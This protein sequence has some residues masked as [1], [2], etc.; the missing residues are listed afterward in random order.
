MRPVAYLIASFSLWFAAAASGAEPDAS[1]PARAE[2]SRTEL[3]MLFI[4]EPHCDKFDPALKGYVYSEGP[5]A[6]EP[7]DVAGRQFAPRA[8]GHPP[9]SY[10]GFL[11]N[12]RFRGTGFF[13][14]RCHILSNCHTA[15]RNQDHPSKSQRSI[16]SFGQDDRT[17]S[18]FA[19]DAVAEPVA[20]GECGCQVESATR[21]NCADIATP[22]QDWALLALAGCSGDGYENSYGYAMLDPLPIR[23][24]ATGELNP[25]FKSAELHAVGQPGTVGLPG[26]KNRPGIDA[27]RLG[28][29][30]SAP[31]Q[32]KGESFGIAW[33]TCPNVS[34]D[35][36]GPIGFLDAAGRLHVVAIQQSQGGREGTN[37]ETD[38]ERVEDWSRDITNFAVPVAG[39]YGRIAPYIG[40]DQDRL[41]R[42]PLP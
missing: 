10:V 38:V 30:I 41:R 25:A 39:F 8:P 42:K 7:C 28:A 26:E 4:L 32:I 27:Y 20:W 3:A 31:C 6:G 36:G 5:R 19:R 13:V 35:S 34:G 17:R 18:S 23:D 12:G 37:P 11:R 14:G 15:F 22:D 33:D 16:F 24:P 9:A 2:S 1:P 29:W 40:D 21:E